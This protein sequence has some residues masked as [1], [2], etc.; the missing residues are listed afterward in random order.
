VSGHHHG[1]REVIHA[2]RTTTTDTG[3]VGRGT[4]SFVDNGQ[5]AKFTF[6]D[7]LRNPARDRIR[8]RGVI[9]TEVSTGTIR[10]ENGEL[11]CLGR[12]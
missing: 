5:I 12:A 9:V 11:T 2:K 10:V 6:T 7:I 1:E 3:F 4:D 8:A